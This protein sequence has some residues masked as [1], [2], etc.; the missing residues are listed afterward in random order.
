MFIHKF[1]RHIYVHLFTHLFHKD[2]SSLN[3]INDIYSFLTKQKIVQLY[4]CEFNERDGNCSPQNSCKTKQ[5]KLYFLFANYIINALSAAQWNTHTY[6]LNTVNTY[7]YKYTVKY[8]TPPSIHTWQ[9]FRRRY[10][11]VFFAM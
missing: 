2:F 8:S 3:S 11:V 1:P 4:S 7:I 6:S 10:N 9:P 5:N